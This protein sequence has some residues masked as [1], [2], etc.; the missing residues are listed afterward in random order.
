[1]LGGRVFLPMGL[2][3]VTQINTS[4]TPELICLWHGGLAA[5]VSDRILSLGLS[6]KPLLKFHGQTALFYL[7][8]RVKDV[9]SKY[10]RRFLSQV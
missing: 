2:L 9:C 4:W 10:V 3:S 6:G 8:V 5:Y 1:M 7:Q